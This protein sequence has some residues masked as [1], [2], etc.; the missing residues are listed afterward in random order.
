VP[1]VSTVALVPLLSC[2]SL[3]SGNKQVAAVL[4]CDHDL[5]GM[6]EHLLHRVQIKTLTGNDGPAFAVSAT[7]CH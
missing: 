6:E 5:A 7:I 2:M 1:V 3:S 4:L